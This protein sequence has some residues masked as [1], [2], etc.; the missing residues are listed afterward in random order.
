MHRK[1]LPFHTTVKDIRFNREA[2]RII[3][4]G[5][6]LALQEFLTQISFM[7]L[8]AFVNRLGLAAP[9]ATT[10]GICINLV[11]YIIFSRQLKKAEA[12]RQ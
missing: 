7:F 11:Y 1:N 4:V 2:L 6:P 8:C 5:T 9:L 3:R 12:G 10:F